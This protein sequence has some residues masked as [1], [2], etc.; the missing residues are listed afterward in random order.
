MK[1]VLL[2]LLIV[3]VAFGIANAL[4]LP[5]QCG[6]ISDWPTFGTEP[7]MLACEHKYAFVAVL[8]VALIVL[9]ARLR[10]A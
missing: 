2:P 7:F 9:A 10:R 4:S 6:G 5:N 3:W 1:S 8:V